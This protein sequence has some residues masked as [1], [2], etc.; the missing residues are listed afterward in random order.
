VKDLR[1]GSL[2]VQEW[3]EQAYALIH[4]YPNMTLVPT[5]DLFERTLSRYIS[6]DHF[7]PNHDGYTQIA[8]RIVQSV[9]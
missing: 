8:I 6:S 9:E 1:E 5:F 4:S 2:E 7:H 3:N